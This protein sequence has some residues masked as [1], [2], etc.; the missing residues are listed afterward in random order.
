MLLRSAAR[1]AC[2]LAALL[3]AALPVDAAEKIRVGVLKFGTVNWELSTIRHHRLDAAEGIDLEV[4]ELASEDATGI[5]LQAGSVD[6]IVTDWLLV[7]RQR[8]AG[9]DLTFHPFSSSVGAIMV[10]EGSP[11]RSLG[12]LKGRV[13][14]V[15]GGP[16]DKNWL[17]IQ[18]LAKRDGLDLGSEATL[19]YGAPP[20]LAEKA[21]QGELDATLNFWQYCARL[22]AKGFRRLLTGA[23]AAKALGAQGPVAA[24][25][26]VFHEK[27]AEA[28]K[29]AML[30]FLRASKAA[31]E[32]LRSSDEEWHRLAPL[33]KAGDEATLKTLMQRFREGI[34]ARP[35]ADEQA[36]A[37][38][39]YAVL[40]AIGGEKLVGPSSTLSPGTYWIHAGEGP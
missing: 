40:A 15:A 18:A 19:N 16:L 27:W 32:I 14:G 30:G 20:L 6:V 31:K 28:H 25:G 11:I 39:L 5:A 4:L 29:D 12:D 22:E 37:A 17:M 13:L 34:P 9:D 26:Y 2:L 33:V 23:E 3:L 7:S 1:V 10:P 36:D 8:A 21:L 24:I 35:L 38:R